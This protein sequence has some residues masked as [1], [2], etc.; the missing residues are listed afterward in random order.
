MESF[1]YGSNERSFK[2]VHQNPKQKR[3][4][5]RKIGRFCSSLVHFC[6]TRVDL[7][8]EFVCYTF[9]AGIFVRVSIDF[10]PVSIISQ[11]KF[12]GEHFQLNSLKNHKFFV[13]LQFFF[14]LFFWCDVQNVYL[15]LVVFGTHDDVGVVQWIRLF[16]KRD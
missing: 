11:A 1:W 4:F 2:N 6:F 15:I 16:C 13:S 12:L 14:L 8:F 7:K 5:F 9:C 10:F 3:V